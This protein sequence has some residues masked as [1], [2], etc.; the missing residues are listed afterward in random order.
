MREFKSFHIKF[1]DRL[2]FLTAY[3]QQQTNKKTFSRLEL[4]YFHHFWL[5]IDKSVSQYLPHFLR[6]NFR[7]KNFYD[8][9]KDFTYPSLK[10]DNLQVRCV[11][12]LVS[13]FVKIRFLWKNI[14]NQ[15][16][17]YLYKCYIFNYYYF[18]LSQN[19][20]YQ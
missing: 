17:F 5:Q 9:N 16:K 20:K 4:V 7:R 10:A 19:L 3:F 2:K 11:N 14:S 8:F 13:F 18:L 6:L 1:G 15:I 12:F